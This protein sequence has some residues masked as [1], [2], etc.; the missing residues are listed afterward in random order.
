M[1]TVTCVAEYYINKGSYTATCHNG[2]IVLTG[3]TPHSVVTTEYD[4]SNM[5]VPTVLVAGGNDWLSK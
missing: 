4:I 2:D 3:N 1:F 5:R